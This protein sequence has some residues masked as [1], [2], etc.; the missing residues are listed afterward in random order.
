M[1]NIMES[2]ELGGIFDEHYGDIVEQLNLDKRILFVLDN[3]LI[4]DEFADLQP[5]LD[6]LQDLDNL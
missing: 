6:N 5:D 1:Q 2:G 3:P 4:P